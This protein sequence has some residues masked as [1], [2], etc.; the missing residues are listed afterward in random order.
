MMMTVYLGMTS[1]GTSSEGDGIG[2][3]EP[4]PPHS[5]MP[6]PPHTTGGEE[7]T[8]DL[9]VLLMPFRGTPLARP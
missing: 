4:A 7:G 3:V 9:T 8:V 1:T 2:T 5:L 6:V